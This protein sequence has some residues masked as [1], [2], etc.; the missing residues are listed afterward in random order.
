MSRDVAIGIVIGGAVSATLGAAIGKTQK[1]VEGLQKGMA[2][3][4]GIKSLIGE[5]QRLQ[6]E[7]AE[8]DKAGRR[9]GLENVRQMRGE[10]AG[11]EK[12]WQRSTAQ[13]AELAKQ[14]NV[15]K[16]A[17][18]G[19]SAALPALEAEHRA[20]SESARLATAH[21]DIKR[22]AWQDG[23]ANAALTR[24]QVLELKKEADGAREASQQAKALAVAKKAQIEAAKGAVDEERKLTGELG[25]AQRAAA[26][27][28]EA[29]EGKRA[30]LQATRSE[31]R[32]TGSTVGEAARQT[33]TLGDAAKQAAQGQQQL[34]N[35]PLRD[36]L[37]ANIGKLREMGVEV[38][39]LD[40]AMR[41][42]QQAEKGMHWQQAGV[43][44][45]QSGVELGKSAGLA[46][47]SAA[48][49]TKISGDF[50]A[51]IRDIAIK[52]GVA[53]KAEEKELTRSIMQAAAD[54]KMDRAALAQAINGLVTQ[55]MDWKEATGHGNLLGE[56]VKGQKM[57]PEDASKL[58]YSFGQNGVKPDQMR[59]TMG[60]VAVAGD[61]GAFESD[62]MA[63]FM[64]ELLATT[65]A[66][67][68]QGPEAVRYIAASLQAQVKLTGDPDS[69]ANNFKN[70]LAKITAPDTD[71][72]FKD[73]GV[74][75]Q[76]SMK[77]YMKAGYNPVESFIALTEKLTAQKD[78]A[79]GKKLEELKAR[80]KNSD[81]NKQAENE[82]LDAYLKMA[83]L[84]DILTDQQARS[85]ALAQIKYGGQ[86]KEDLTKIKN[87]DGGKKLAGDKAARDDTS[88]SRWEAVH[89]DFNAAMISVGDAIRPVTNMVAGFASSLLQLGTGFAQSHPEA[90]MLGVGAA[91]VTLGIAAKRI[92][93]GAV[94][95]GAGK[96]LTTLGGKVGATAGGKDV[97][98]K[99]AD[100]V[101]GGGSAVG[102]Q[103]VF[104]TNW[105]GGGMPDMGGPGGA[106]NG[107]PGAKPA[108]GGGRLG[109]I[110]A[111]VR[112]GVARVGGGI[113]A[114]RAAGL[115][116]AARG[117][118]RVAG[119]AGG[120]AIAVGAAAYQV[121]DTYK[122]AKTAEAKGKGY[123][124][125]A[126]GLAG[127]L[128]GAKVGALVGTMILPGIGTV[129]GGLIGS[130]AGALIGTK[131][132][133]AAGGVVG[134]VASST[135]TPGA[136]AK[137]A[138][139]GAAVTTAANGAGVPAK[140]SAAPAA[141]VR[142]AVA[143]STP[144]PT[145]APK[146]SAPPHPP[147]QHFTFSPTVQVKVMGDVKKPEE[148]AA[149][150]A[151]HLKRLFDQWVAAAK[152]SGGGGM[153]DPVGG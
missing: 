146:G 21:A 52:A 87:T 46:I 152:K 124:G 149:Q 113:Q 122:N 49:P 76:E 58:I 34:A 125:A 130:V 66:L 114:A 110:G 120:A 145:A 151:P 81:G 9:I 105:P 42:L 30:A 28:K 123:G 20:L 17:A 134:R 59:K 100:V 44:K 67:G 65:G 26:S 33:V 60:E 126:G 117:A 84:A 148:I 118:M 142:P 89:A 79:Q 63:K 77:A 103:R 3:T 133:E 18:A 138:K 74:S 98:S 1:S 137:A 93:G 80:I 104:V 147:A 116:G 25:K 15:A 47:G 153:Y 72:K 27:A 54:Q 91:A 4:K 31:L 85:G 35:V 136:V 119:K 127:G 7:L 90:A 61:L 128:A 94:Q 150:I 45:M 92:V 69:A 38:G 111:A 51:E 68:F 140:P 40:R 132:G 141:P 139:P 53:N 144:A 56:L 41:K 5:T 82:A 83:G 29:W 73:A 16:Q 19:Q 71:K 32:N 39:N 24:Q 48:V 2:D 115:G 96:V 75:L 37:A 143:S 36:K 131:I 8:A 12:D 108:A 55:G 11:L 109:R 88:N 62:K 112:S 22:A 101:G 129:V 70:L 78:P 14:L 107:K 95:W 57:A 43:G 99:L 121:Y 102:V 13:V 106:G 64:P 10:L 97:A 6:R 86:I 23:K 50:Q 135:P